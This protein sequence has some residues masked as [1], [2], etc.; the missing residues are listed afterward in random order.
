[1]VR[2]KF[3]SCHTAFK[4]EVVGFYQVVKNAIG[5]MQRN[6]DLLPIIDNL[7]ELND[8]PTLSQAMAYH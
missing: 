6:I 8:K 5:E 3:Y 7:G 2:K 4:L 1:M